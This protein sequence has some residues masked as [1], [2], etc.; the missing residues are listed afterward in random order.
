M[1]TYRS[2]CSFRA[3]DNPFTMRSGATIYCFTKL[4]GSIANLRSNTWIL[5]TS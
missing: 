3:A 5:R 4:I 1:S 2:I